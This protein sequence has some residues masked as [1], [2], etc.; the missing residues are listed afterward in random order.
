MTSKQ[1]KSS[2]KKSEHKTRKIRSSCWRTNE[3]FE[4]PFDIINHFNCFNWNFFAQKVPFWSIIRSYTLWI[5]FSG[6]HKSI[7]TKFWKICC[8]QTGRTTLVCLLVTFPP[9]HEHIIDVCKAHTLNDFRRNKS[10]YTL[11]TQIQTQKMLAKKHTTRQKYNTIQTVGFITKTACQVEFEQTL[12][13]MKHL[14]NNQQS[15]FLYSTK[16][17]QFKKIKNTNQMCNLLQ[18]KLLVIPQRTEWIS[19]TNWE[20]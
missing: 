16:E 3:N 8:W 6:D 17:V 18:G 2:H 9:S 12:F 14:R 5:R 1:T 19:K 15:F 4:K 20:A 7:G 10:F 13:L 11:Q